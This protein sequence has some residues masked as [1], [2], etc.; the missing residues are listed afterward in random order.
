M[1]IGYFEGKPGPPD[2]PEITKV[3]RDNAMVTWSA[4]SS[5]G[6]REVNGYWVEKQEKRGVR[7]TPCNTKLIMDRRYIGFSYVNL[8]A[9]FT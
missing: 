5:D 1:T 8:M 6:G 4:P 7:W 3:G 2:R 9:V